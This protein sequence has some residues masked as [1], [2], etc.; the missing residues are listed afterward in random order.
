MAGTGSEPQNHFLS[1]YICQEGNLREDKLPAKASATQDH[2]GQLV[3][4]GRPRRKQTPKPLPHAR[5]T[6]HAGKTSTTYQLL[7]GTQR[8]VM[9]DAPLS[10]HFHRATL[11]SI[12]P[13][14]PTTYLAANKDFR[15]PICTVVGSGKLK[16]HASK[17]TLSKACPNTSH[18]SAF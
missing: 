18:R 15:H 3:Q 13:G 12:K 11:P 2:Q 16:W 4:E 7:A 5:Q 1:H 6:H 14:L 9:K 17:T 8:M 10:F